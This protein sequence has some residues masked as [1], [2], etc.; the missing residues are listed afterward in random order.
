MSV[1]LRTGKGSGKGAPPVLHFYFNGKNFCENYGYP[2]EGT[3]L[4]ELSSKYYDGYYP[5][6]PH[7]LKEVATNFKQFLET[8]LRKTPDEISYSE[9]EHLIKETEEYPKNEMLIELLEGTFGLKFDEAADVNKIVLQELFIIF[10]E[11]FEKYDGDDKEEVLEKLNMI[12]SK[13]ETIVWPHGGGPAGGFRLATL[14]PR[15]WESWMHRF[16]TGI[17]GGAAGGGGASGGASGSARM[18]YTPKKRRS[19]RRKRRTTRKRRRSTRRKRRT[20][21]KRRKTRKTRKTRRSTRRKRRTRKTRKGK[22]ME[23]FLKGLDG[24]EKMGDWRPITDH[25][26]AGKDF[27]TSRW[28][29]VKKE[30]IRRGGRDWSPPVAVTPFTA[31]QVA[32]GAAPPILTAVAVPPFTAGRGTDRYAPY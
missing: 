19:T 20:T 6:Q 15:F 22:G 29:D 27:A 8:Y 2:D 24:T 25:K 5:F 23:Y 16:G 26:D 3:Y 7:E 9:L 28:R 21:R 18:K 32:E 13:F 17:A 11:Q 1:E 12:D 31:P 14:D 4:R 10:K 30:L